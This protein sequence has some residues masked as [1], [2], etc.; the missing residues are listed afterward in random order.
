[1]R[2]SAGTVAFTAAIVGLLL[3]IAGAALGLGLLLAQ[4]GLAAP[5]RSLPGNPWWFRSS[6]PV[7]GGSAAALWRIGAAGAA[8]CI[9]CLAAMRGRARDPKGSSPIRSFTTVFLFSL[10]LECLRAG[11]ALLYAVDGPVS[12][13]IMLTRV[14]Y[15]GRFTGLLGLLVASL[16][17]IDMKL[18]KFTILAGA[19]FI[20]SFAMAAYIP[21][22]RTVFL[23]QLTW[24]LGDEQGVWFVNTMIGILVVLTGGAGALIRRDAAAI[25]RAAGLALFIVSRELLFFATRPTLLGAGLGALLAGIVVSLSA[26]PGVKD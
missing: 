8:A 10:G 13:A 1:M 9:A 25:L 20:V 7:E 15:W 19:V 14:M 2:A 26:L 24:K 16:Y 12:V 17:C 11:T 5:L 21:M 22:D 4:P 6:E 18:Q 3:L 23:S